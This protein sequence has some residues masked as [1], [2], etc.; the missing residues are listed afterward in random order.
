MEVSFLSRLTRCLAL[1]P[2]V[3]TLNESYLRIGGMSPQ[4]RG[5][6][7][8]KNIVSSH[9]AQQGKKRGLLY[10]LQVILSSYPNLSREVSS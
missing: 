8:S 5:W 6:W 4:G 1:S 10:Y 7:G 9:I 3:T 2:L